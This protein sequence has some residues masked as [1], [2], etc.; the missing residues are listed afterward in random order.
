[1]SR[2]MVVIV[3][4]ALA[5]AVLIWRAA[6][7]LPWP[8]RAL[9]VFLLALLPALLVGQYTVAEDA[10]DEVPRGTIYLSSAVAL[11]VLAG[12]AV[13]VA[14]ASGFTR[15]LLGLTLLPVGEVAAWSIGTTVA[16]LGLMAVG[17]WFRFR[18]T[19]LLEHLLPR[20]PRERLGFAGLSLSAG[21]GEE[22]VFRSFLIPALTVAVGS[23]WFAALLS[24]AVFGI[25]HTY[26]HAFGS[27]RAAL[28]GLLL[29]V[30]FIVTGSVLP[31]M[32][33]H[34]ALDLIAGIWLADWLLR[35]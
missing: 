17:R 28:L 31:S 34:T 10:I 7:P 16:G 2:K 30:P 26:Q 6:D 15:R 18:E 19:R 24:S 33:A 25:L 20:T 29:A 4:A 8:A 1:M 27:V 3:V 35:R 5:L 11:W 22:L 9:V 23:I 12:V 32:I 13:G 14:F 21:V